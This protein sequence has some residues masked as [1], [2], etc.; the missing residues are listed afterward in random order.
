MKIRRNFR[1][2]FSYVERRSS[3]PFTLRN[4]VNI[5]ISSNADLFLKYTTY[6]Q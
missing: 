2:G 3:L 5:R 4:I 1:T 6:T